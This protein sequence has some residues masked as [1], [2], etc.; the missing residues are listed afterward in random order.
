MR[1]VIVRKM[2][3]LAI[4]VAASAVLA[5][6]RTMAPEYNKP[7]LPVP[8]AFPDADAG[9]GR[10]AAD[11]PWR[12]FFGDE[13]LKSLVAMAL[14][15][16]RDLRSAV[17]NIERARALYR[18]QRSEQFPTVDA[19]ASAAVQRV[20][21]GVNGA[22][23]GVTSDQYSASVG[24]SYELDLFG[25]IRSLNAQALETFL[26]TEQ[27]RRGVQIGLVSEVAQAYLTFAADR[28]QLHLAQSTLE[29]Q[30]KAYE[31]TRQRLDAGIAN[32][33]AV[34]QAQTSVETARADVARYTSLVSR[35]RNAL[36]L[37]VGA[38]VPDAML[39]N[40]PIEQIGLLAD[41]PAGLPS[42]VLQQ[43]PDILAAEHQLRGAYANIG[44]ARAQLFPSIRLTA[45]AGTASAA[46]SGLFAAGS[47]AW[48]F[49]PQISAPIFNAG[50][51]RANVRVAE[52]DRDLAVASYEGAIQI[53]FRE[54]ADALA[55]RRTLDERLSAQQALVEANADSY[56]LSDARFKGGVDSYLAVLD[57]QRSLY[58]S[59]Q[60]LIDIRLARISN[61]VTLY[62]ALGGGWS[63][64][65]ATGG[66]IA[67]AGALP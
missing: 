64:P 41:L 1:G 55:D 50:R 37:V 61:L 42:D 65:A 14:D 45:S 34:R 51:N 32:S 52:V 66:A 24:A 40:G 25:R 33:L 67:T 39:P 16:N 62:R 43:R 29:N 9:A 60:G 36:A 8:D 31:L 21:Q 5:G 28:E 54:V 7:A 56:R 10:A 4:A 11:I 23:V 15:H 47:G 38:P 35:D 53:A 59:Q 27:A 49:V 20:P 18:I 58:A 46:L 30:R 3:G 12:E 6:C 26:A 57:S 48:S 19:G 44:A 2:T 13:K 22:P 63:E 17:L